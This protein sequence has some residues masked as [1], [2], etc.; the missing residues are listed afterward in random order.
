MQRS[1]TALCVCFLIALCG[2]TSGEDTQ[3]LRLAN[4]GGAG[5]E[6]EFD[7]LIQRI[8]VEFEAANPGVQIRV[9]NNPENYT[10]KMV[11]SFIAGAE[12]DIMMLDASYAATFIENGVLADLS[13]LIARDPEFRL[14]D[15]FQNVTDIARRGD[16]LYAIPQ[17]F[18]PMVL[19]YNKKLF[20]EAGV[21]YPQSGWSFD[22]FLQTVKKLT[23]PGRQYGFVL[24]NWMP[25]WV[26]WIWNNGG[27]VLSPEGNKASGYLNGPKSAEAVQFL[28]DLVNKHKVAPSLSQVASLGVDPF[29]NGQAAMTVS[30][31][32]SM[33][34]YAKAPK[35]PDGKPTLKWDD[36]GVV[37]LPTN[38]ETSHTVMYESGFA[39]G[40][41]C[42]QKDLAWKFVKFMTSYSVQSRYNASG[43]AVC[44]RKDVAQERGKLPLEAQFLPI[45]PTA[46]PPLGALVEGY[47]FVEPAG[48]GAM[49][50][51][52]QGRRTAE[53][54]LTKAARK[55]DRNFAK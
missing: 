26:M 19:Y 53:E 21:P 8:Y 10:A 55:V 41:N 11:L 9:E 52:L 27:E 34:D 42:K 20:D 18:T 28:A 49:D 37:S 16:S 30:G 15:F 36:L 54:A 31:H 29:L 2:C 12:P 38:V 1:I 35:G 48:Q 43:I 3:I 7:L 33:I 6:G 40:K 17:D 4:W 46:R 25:G 45:V 13:P 14:D 44:A 5:G 39:I 23:K 47:A 22:D 50:S 32:W 24:N 51:V